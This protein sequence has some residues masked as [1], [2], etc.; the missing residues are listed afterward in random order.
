[1]DIND[2]RAINTVLGFLCFIG[3]VIWA[4]SGSPKSRF[5]EAAKLPFADDDLPAGAA[6]EQLGRGKAS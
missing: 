2:F 1:M 5:E 3:I 6:G 4:Y